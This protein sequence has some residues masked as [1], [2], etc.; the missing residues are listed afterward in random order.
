MGMKLSPTRQKQED[1]RKEKERR[2]RRPLPT[3][4][5]LSLGSKLKL[6]SAV[7]FYEWCHYPYLT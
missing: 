3:R 6:S 4:H 5:V 7:A 2:Y 1:E